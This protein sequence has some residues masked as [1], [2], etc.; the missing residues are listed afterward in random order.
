M[1]L[2]FFRLGKKS[3]NLSLRDLVV[4]G[5]SPLCNVNLPWS[6]L[7]HTL[8]MR[9]SHKLMNGEILPFKER[10][11]TT[12]D[13]QREEADLLIKPAPVKSQTWRKPGNRL[14]SVNRASQR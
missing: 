3:F 11:E 14:V 7:I 6:L 10:R 12:L 2:P 1:S 13:K 4:N 5:E 8:P 9:F